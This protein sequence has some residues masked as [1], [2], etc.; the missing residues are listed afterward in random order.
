MNN[1]SYAQSGFKR[2][3]FNWVNDQIWNSPVYTM[4]DFRRIGVMVRGSPFHRFTAAFQ[5]SSTGMDSDFYDYTS[6]FHN[7]VDSSNYLSEFEL[8]PPF[9][10]VQIRWFDGAGTAYIDVFRR[11]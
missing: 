2:S 3:T 9:F 1:V 7:G 5:F 10:R 8:T 4:D 11:T 6:L